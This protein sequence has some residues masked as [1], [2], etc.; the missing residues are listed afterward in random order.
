MERSMFGSL[1]KAVN[2]ARAVS[3]T[4]SRLLASPGRKPLGS[5]VM[6]RRG[7]PRDVRVDEGSPGGL[8][9]A[10]SGSDGG[11][12]RGSSTPGG[13]PGPHGDPRYRSRS[14]PDAG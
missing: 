6:G 3:A 5:Q 2:P 10:R 14:S 8:G 4:N 13:E 9:S 12:I 11:S 7:R 1:F